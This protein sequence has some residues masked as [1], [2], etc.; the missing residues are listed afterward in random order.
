[1][2]CDGCEEAAAPGG[3]KLLRCQAIQQEDFDLLFSVGAVER[4]DEFPR[5]TMMEI[6]S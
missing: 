4:G 3:G 6:F 2:E 5:S 1:M